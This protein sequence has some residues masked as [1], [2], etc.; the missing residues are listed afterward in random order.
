MANERAPTIATVIQ[1]EV[2]DARPAVDRQDRADVGVGQRE[3]RVLEAHEAHEALRECDGAHRPCAV[4]SERSSLT[5]CSSTG[6]STAQP[7]SQARGLPG[8]VITIVRARM[9]E[10]PRESAAVRRVPQRVGAQGLVDARAQP[11]ERR[12][13]GLGRDVARREARAAG[14]EHDVGRVLVAQARE[15]RGDLVALVGQHAPPHDLV[16]AGDGALGQHRAR[17]VL[18]RAV[19][20]AVGDREHGDPHGRTQWPD[21]PPSFSSSTIDSTCPPASMPFVMS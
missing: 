13:R 8:R 14:R 2:R 6:S 3:D 16:P 10:T 11:L 17:A 7:S 12:T 19:V 21:L 18:A 5:A 9:P 4:G 20:H 1:H 15:A